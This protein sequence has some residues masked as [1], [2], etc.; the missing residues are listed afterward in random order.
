[1]IFTDIS[2]PC[3][4]DIESSKTV[5]GLR[6]TTA[7]AFARVVYHAGEPGGRMG[8]EGACASDGKSHVYDRTRI[9]NRYSH[10]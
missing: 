9:V 3:C 1:M 8:P 7:A 2:S 5:E 10:R 4:L 6:P